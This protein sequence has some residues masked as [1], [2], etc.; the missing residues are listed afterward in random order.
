MEF[1]SKISEQIVFNTKPKIEEHM[2]FV[3][4]DSN[5]EEFYFNHH[6]QIINNLR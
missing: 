3:S 1:P 4:D 2:L 6:K 5:H